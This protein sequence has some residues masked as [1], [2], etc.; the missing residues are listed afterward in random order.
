MGTHAETWDEKFDQVRKILFEL[1]P[2]ETAARFVDLYRIHI[3]SKKG[4]VQTE[5]R[6]ELTYRKIVQLEEF[7]LYWEEMRKEDPDTSQKWLIDK[8]V[9]LKLPGFSMENNIGIVKLK[10]L[11]RISSLIHLKRTGWVDNKI[12]DP[13]RVAG[14]MFR[15][16]VMAAFF[17]EDEKRSEEIRIGERNGTA[18][19]ISMLH[20][21]AECIVGDITPQEGV[22]DEKKHE[23][24]D[25]AMKDLVKELPD[26]LASEIKTAFDRYENQTEGDAEARL[27]KDLD[28]F[29]MILQAFEYEQNKA[30]TDKKILE[31]NGGKFLQQFFDSTEGKFKT[32]NVKNLVK[33]LKELRN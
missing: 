4:K 20:D 16:G 33:T 26:T 23:M 30:V 24:E 10:F 9:G 17:E 18:V 7:I 2:F 14:H 19:I 27:T 15:M 6:I 3:T 1:L 21:V 32:E 31:E 28:K 8:M 5:D 29:D 25:N 11:L 12:R 13:E 22:P